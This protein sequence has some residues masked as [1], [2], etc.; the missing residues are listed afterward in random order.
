MFD[1]GARFAAA[2]R[3]PGSFAGEFATQEMREADSLQIYE[4]RSDV[5][6]TVNQWCPPGSGMDGSCDPSANPQSSTTRITTEVA[7][8]VRQPILDL[9][10]LRYTV[11][12]GLDFSPGCTRE[13]WRGRMARFPSWNRCPP[14][15][16]LAD[17]LVTAELYSGDAPLRSAPGGER[18]HPPV[19]PVFLSWFRCRCRAPVLMQRRLRINAMQWFPIPST[20]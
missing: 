18:K 12:D 13:P 14:F 15:Y 9:F 17:W 10:G 7:Y 2:S 4:D 8:T 3:V 1:P 19:F 20:R 16:E 5:I 11:A 6:G